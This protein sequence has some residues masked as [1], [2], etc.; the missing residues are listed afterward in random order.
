MQKSKKWS[1]WIHYSPVQNDS[2]NSNKTVSM[3]CW[4]SFKRT[5][6]WLFQGS[7]HC[8]VSLCIGCKSCFRT[9]RIVNLPK[10]L[11]WMVIVLHVGFLILLKT[12]YLTWPHKIYA[13]PMCT[14]AQHACELLGSCLRLSVLVGCVFDSF[15]IPSKTQNTVEM[16]PMRARRRWLP[17]T[18][19]VRSGKVTY[20]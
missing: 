5:S 11:Y 4:W 9:Q 6:G 20:I 8:W 7:H 13:S 10:V 19:S 1:Y 12:P 2:V 3:C 15:E 16:R 14:V 18:L 17:M